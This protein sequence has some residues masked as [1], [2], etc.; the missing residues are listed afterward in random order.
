M[1]KK[2]DLFFFRLISGWKKPS[3]FIANTE[4]N[5]KKTHLNIYVT[6]NY[7]MKLKIAIAYSWLPQYL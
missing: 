3:N 7:W 5:E 1:D 6:G 4:L 2:W